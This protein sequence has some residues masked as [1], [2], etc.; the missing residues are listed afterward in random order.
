MKMRRREILFRGS[1]L[2]A[3]VIVSGRFER[4]FAEDTVSDSKKEFIRTWLQAE[5]GVVPGAPSR[6]AVGVP[7]LA[8]FADWDYYYTIA[9]I[10][11]EPGDKYK[12]RLRSVDVPTGFVTD[13]ASIPRIFWSALPKTGKYGHA[14]IVHDY[15]YWI[16]SRP[17]EI[18]D[19]I[20]EID[21]KE[22][23]TPSWQ[24]VAISNAVKTF[25]ERAWTN[26]ADLR[27]RGEKRVLKLFPDDPKTS[28]S[29]WKKRNDIWVE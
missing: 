26:S 2:I 11:W 24:V 18:A 21:M 12:D 6:P 20:L 27:S 7:K 10:S 25:G 5:G 13:L 3:G 28:W 14:A 17:R 9:P 19:E 29:E 15:L 16:Q 23:G 22:L 4:A 8:P 1:A